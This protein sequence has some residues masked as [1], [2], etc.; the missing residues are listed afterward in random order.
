M[1]RYVPAALAGAV[2]LSA[3]APLASDSPA[4]GLLCPPLAVYSPAEQEAAADAL[5]ALPSEHILARM[6][7]NYGALREALRSCEA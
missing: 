5:A 6:M 1:R 7:I 3:C 2:C 4:Q